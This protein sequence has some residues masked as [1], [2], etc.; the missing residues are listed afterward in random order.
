[1]KGI[2]A[3]ILVP[4]NPGL[5]LDHGAEIMVQHYVG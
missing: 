1:M 2:H 5:S 3:A 4:F